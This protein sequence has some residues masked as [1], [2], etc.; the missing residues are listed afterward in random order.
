M[1]SSDPSRVSGG[2][3]ARMLVAQPSDASSASR[4]SAYR[5]ARSGST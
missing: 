2:V 3:L 1:P 4:T 5:S